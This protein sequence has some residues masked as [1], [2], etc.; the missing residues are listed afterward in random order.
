ME[1][2]YLNL[3]KEDESEQKNAQLKRFEP[4]IA[5]FILQGVIC[6]IV[7]L[8]CL[9]TKTF[10][11]DFFGE[12]KNFYDENLNE[13]TNP[14]LVLESAEDTRAVGGPLEVSY[15]GTTGGF[16]NP[17]PSGVITSGYGY[18]KD[19][20]T[21]KTAF[22]SG[23]DIAASKGTPIKSALSGVVELSQK[24]GG[25]YGNYIIV[26]HGAFK[27][28]Y[29]HCEEL[30]VNEGDFVSVGERIATV[31]STGRSTGPHLHFEIRVG[32]T[33]IDPTPFIKLENK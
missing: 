2:D 14:S 6:V 8:V 26:N 20:F 18:R 28:L 11:G 5:I 9:I 12:I 15:L 22:H 23:L 30:T 21:N 25:D 1:Q 27:T 10:F 31:G 4:H 19:P 24:S 7:L 32:N 17:L 29:A 3:P 13:D 33:K 16:Q